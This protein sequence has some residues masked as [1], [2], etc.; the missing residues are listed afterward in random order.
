MDVEDKEDFDE[1]TLEYQSDVLPY[2]EVYRVNKF[3]VIEISQLLDIISSVL[4][5]IVR[6]TDKIPDQITTSFHA[7][8]KPG[9]SIKDY[10]IRIEKCS[11]CSDECFILALI[12]IDRLTERNSRIILKSLNVH[13]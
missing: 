13:R 11:K 10:L 6:E 1:S 7:K 8:S 9:I 2:S 12:Y 3:R 5:E 4:G